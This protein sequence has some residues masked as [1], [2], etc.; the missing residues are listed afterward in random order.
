MYLSVTSSFIGITLTV[1]PTQS[2]V[3]YIAADDPVVFL[4]LKNAYSVNVSFTFILVI[5]INP[6]FLEIEMKIGR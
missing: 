5:L 3:V 1:W 6:P 4:T 2:G